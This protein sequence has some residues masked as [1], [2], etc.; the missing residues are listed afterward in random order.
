M[1]HKD[2]AT[3]FKLAANHLQLNPFPCLYQLRHAGASKDFRGC[4]RT[5]KEVKRS[6]HWKTDASLRR[7]EKGGR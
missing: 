2:L 5:L 6:G 1:D 4:L 7:Y 3:Q